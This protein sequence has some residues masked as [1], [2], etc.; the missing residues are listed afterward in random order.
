MKFRFLKNFFFLLI[1]FS[2]Q[3]ATH[4]KGLTAGD[5]YDSE[6]SLVFLLKF[7]SKA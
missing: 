2:L 1:G 7:A 3:Q 5:M 4:L 6:V